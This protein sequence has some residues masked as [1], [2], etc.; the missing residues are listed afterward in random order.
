MVRMSV[1]M[2]HGLKR[3]CHCADSLGRQKVCQSYKARFGVFNCSL[4]GYAAED[5]WGQ[6]N[7]Q[8]GYHHSRCR[9]W[10]L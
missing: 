2:E 3:E 5:A 10:G 8:H 1:R 6:L 9:A 4:V 7:F